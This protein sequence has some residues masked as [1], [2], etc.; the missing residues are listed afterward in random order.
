MI[1]FNKIKSTFSKKKI[2]ETQRKKRISKQRRHKK[3][4]QNLKKRVPLHTRLPL[5]IVDY[6]TKFLFPMDFF[7]LIFTCKFFFYTFLPIY[8]KAEMDLRDIVFLI[9]SENEGK[10]FG[11][12]VRDILRKEGIPRDYD[13]IFPKDQ[14]IEAVFKCLKSKNNI[15]VIISKKSLK[16]KGY[17]NQ[18]LRENHYGSSCQSVQTSTIRSGNVS[19]NADF[20]VG[21]PTR[22]KK[23][24]MDFDINSLTID[25]TYMT[26]E[27][28]DSYDQTNLNFG[29]PSAL[30]KQLRVRKPRGLTSVNRNSILKQIQ[31]KQMSIPQGHIDF[32]LSGS[33]P[34][35]VIV[36]INKFADP[37]LWKKKLDPKTLTNWM[38]ET[39]PLILNRLE[40]LEKMIKRGWTIKNGE[41]L[42][43]APHSD[44]DLCSVC[45]CSTKD[46]I[47]LK[48]PYCDCKTTQCINCF[49]KILNDPTIENVPCDICKQSSILY[50]LYSVQ[51]R[52][53]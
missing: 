34:L 40:R 42:K 22:Q 15:E 20:V 5:E 16:S 11:G 48:P 19:I 12:G 50:L 28:M 24:G 45:S 47:C 10:L 30:I 3:Y 21:N 9:V 43:F 8:R 53:Y 52:Y 37:S 26:Q 44:D 18:R 46:L 41:I 7:S 36:E 13:F 31:E 2:M 17:C 49:K 6:I 27:I 39:K 32:L 1:Y 33:S 4:Q 51:T 38:F 14:Q 23:Q 35:K 25:P 29:I